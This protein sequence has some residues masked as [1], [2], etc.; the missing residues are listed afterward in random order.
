LKMKKVASGIPGL[1]KLLGGGIPEGTMTLLTGTCGAGKTIFCSQFLA[2]SSEPGVYVSFEEETDEL[3][4]N[5]AI[6]GWDFDRMEKQDRIRIL[7][8]DPFRIED[9]LEVVQ[10]NMRQIKAKRAVF[11]S[12]AALGVHMKEASELRRMIL[13]I[14]NIMKRDNVT[15]LIVSEIMPGSSGVSRFGVEEFVSDGVI[16][17]DNRMIKSELTRAVG[18]LKMR[19]V[20]HSKFMHPYTITDKGITVSSATLRS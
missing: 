13:Q 8:Y 12:V 3:R 14:N 16:L 6:F 7:K 1:D 9:I 4:E 11:D 2:N 15:T 17:L 20:N 10:N 19:G 5:A 18:V